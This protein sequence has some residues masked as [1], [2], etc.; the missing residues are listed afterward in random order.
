MNRA[1]I[2]LLLAF[3]LAGCAT[4]KFHHGQ[5]PYDKGYVAS[6]DSYTIPGYTLGKDNSVPADLA[7]AKQRFSRRR[8]V[9]E[10]YYKKMGAIE[11]RFK[12][13]VYDPAVMFIKLIGGVFRLPFIAI[14]DYKYDH[15]PAYREKV[16][17]LEEEKDL[18]EEARIA[19]LREKLSAYINKTLDSENY[20]VSAKQGKSAKTLPKAELVA[21][22][23]S[24]I[25]AS[26]SQAATGVSGQAIPVQSPTAVSAELDKVQRE[27]KMAQTMQ[28]LPQEKP[29]KK[30][31]QP[32]T[33]APSGQPRAIII[34][35]PQKGFSPLA[36]HLYGSRSTS[37]QGAIVSYSWDFGD[38]DTSEKANPVN[39]YY[40][41]SF[42]PQQFTVTLTVKDSRG[43]TA[44]TSSVI[45]VLNR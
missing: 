17:K 6:R 22:E 40:S 36:V 10:D 2:L 31:A 41:G 15:N 45:E 25:E 24:Q 28:R 21:K 8:R 44:T 23:L 9:V 11:N 34:A 16:R 37:P 18:R 12:M 35:K 29:A 20:P 13:A 7:L 27:Q 39:T 30:V 43:N 1:V 38:G 4:Y 3:F 26:S 14:S 33:P 5:A 42:Q 32:K 19:R